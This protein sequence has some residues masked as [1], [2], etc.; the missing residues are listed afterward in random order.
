MPNNVHRESPYSNSKCCR[1]YREV[2]IHQRQQD[3]VD[4]EMCFGSGFVFYRV[5]GHLLNDRGIVTALMHSG[6]A[7]LSV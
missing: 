6:G 4:S 5:C 7:K 1:I 2:Q 3:P